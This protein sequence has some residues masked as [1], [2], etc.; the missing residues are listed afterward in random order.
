MERPQRR[1]LKKKKT[2]SLN[3]LVETANRLPPC[4]SG[5]QRLISVIEGPPAGFQPRTFRMILWIKALHVIVVI[6]WMA[7]MLYLPRLFVYHA[8][9][10][11]ARDVR[12]VQGH[13]APPSQSH[14]QSVDDRRL[15]DRTDPR[16]CHGILAVVAGFTPSSFWLL[17]LPACT[18]IL[19][20]P[21]GCSRRMRM[22][23]RPDSI[24]VLNEVPTVLMILI[25]LLAVVKPF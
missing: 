22:S 3:L 8:D 4:A 25:V 5:I 21:F 13:G 2:A 12:D 6:A 14:R 20:A 1:P 23:G 19:L 15:P 11:R 17:V 16:L 9:A 24:A 18:A 7:G 10:R